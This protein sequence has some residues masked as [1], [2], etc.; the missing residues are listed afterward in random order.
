MIKLCACAYKKSPIFLG[1]F[2]FY[3]LYTY[4]ETP[5][6]EHD[7]NVDGETKNK[8]WNLGIAPRFESCWGKKKAP[9]NAQVHGL[10]NES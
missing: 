4:S 9:E 6:V 10:E 2:F 1:L 5:S 8:R 3:D 7:S